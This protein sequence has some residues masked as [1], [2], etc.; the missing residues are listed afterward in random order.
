MTGL[1]ANRLRADSLKANQQ[2][3]GNRAVELEVMARG[4]PLDREENNRRN[5]RPMHSEAVG[6]TTQTN[7]LDGEANPVKR[8]QVCKPTVNKQTA[9]NRNVMVHRRVR[10]EDLTCEGGDQEPC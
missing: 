5:K 7:R 1:D 8:R 2:N 10:E 4:P 9:G 6:R 3:R